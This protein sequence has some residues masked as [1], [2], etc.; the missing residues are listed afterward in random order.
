MSTH[1]ISSVLTLP[2]KGNFPHVLSVSCCF[3]FFK[4]NSGIPSDCQTVWI[5][6]RQ[7]VR[8]D[9]GPNCLQRLSAGKESNMKMIWPYILL[10]LLV[11][12]KQFVPRSGLTECWCRSGSKQFD[13][14]IV[15]LKEFFGK[16][17]SKKVSRQHQ[18]LSY[19]ACKELNID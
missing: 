11:I 19:P 7:K 14:L 4:I 5:Q 8:P 15:F 12:C 1:N 3:F 17:N 13:T 2:T 16:I 6:L 18:N 10:T 9:L